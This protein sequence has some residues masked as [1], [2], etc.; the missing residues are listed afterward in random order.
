M[1]EYLVHTSIRA[2]GGPVRRVARRVLLARRLAAAAQA[3]ARAAGEPAVRERG[4]PLGRPA[5]RAA[6]APGPLV[7][8]RLVLRAAHAGAHRALGRGHV[9]RV[10]GVRRDQVSHDAARDVER[11]QHRAQV[12]PQA[13]QP[14]AAGARARAGRDAHALGPAADDARGHDH[15]IAARLARGVRRG[16]AQLAPRVRLGLRHLGARAVPAVEP[17]QTVHRHV[18]RA[19]PRHWAQARHRLLEAAQAEVARRGARRRPRQLASRAPRAPRRLAAVPHARA[20]CARPAAGGRA[21][22]RAALVTAAPIAHSLLS[23]TCLC[24]P[25]VQLLDHS[26]SQ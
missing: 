26:H 20:R 14:A 23:L 6:G 19:R 18:R 7:E 25:L 17:D 21:R 22:R 12:G 5:A 9:E 16:L 2:P 11:E 1:Y 13:V 15:R 4:R 10:H 8:P 24:L 3:L